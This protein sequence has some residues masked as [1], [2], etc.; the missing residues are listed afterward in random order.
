MT[1]YKEGGGRSLLEGER[2]IL[3]VSLLSHKITF[4]RTLKLFKVK[5]QIR[6]RKS[7]MTNQGYTKI[8]NQLAL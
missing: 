8:K 5:H 2:R 3:L 4:P 7:G 6:D 1:E